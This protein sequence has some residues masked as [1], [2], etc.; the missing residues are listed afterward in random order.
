MSAMSGHT[1]LLNLLGGVAL[2][3]WGTH[4]VQ[5]AILRAYGAELRGAIA[6]AAGKATAAGRSLAV[7]AASVQS[8]TEGSLTSPVTKKASAATATIRFL[9]EAVRGLRC[10]T[11]GR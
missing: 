2:L 8:R 5:S 1:I 11:A 10:P 4:M 9:S 3:L 7:T 6:R